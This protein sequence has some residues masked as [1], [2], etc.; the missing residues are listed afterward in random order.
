VVAV[1]NPSL[2]PVNRTRIALPKGNY[3][4]SFFDQDLRA[5]VNMT[6]ETAVIICDVD[7]S[8]SDENCWLH[9]YMKVRGHSITFLKIQRNDTHGLIQAIPRIEN[10]PNGHIVINNN[11]QTV[12][13]V[14]HNLTNGAIFRIQKDKYIDTYHLGFD[15]RYY[16]SYQGFNYTRGGAAV[17]RPDPGYS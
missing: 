2:L 3:S 16:N 7:N 13:Y 17:F 9:A 6:N 10:A 12:E 8:R 11:M 14:S 4:V 15:L 1:F 5:F